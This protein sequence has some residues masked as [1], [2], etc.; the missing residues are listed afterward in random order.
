MGTHLSN[1]IAQITPIFSSG[2][3]Q[4]GH[5]RS[6]SVVKV[7]RWLW[8]IILGI[9]FIGPLL[10]VLGF[11]LVAGVIFLTLLFPLVIVGL[12]SIPFMLS[13]A[14][15]GRPFPQRRWRSWRNNNYNWRGPWGW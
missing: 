12:F 9:M 4:Y 7:A 14:L 10:H 13:R 8:F 1:S 3:F 5:A 6:G 11:L 2:V 15:T